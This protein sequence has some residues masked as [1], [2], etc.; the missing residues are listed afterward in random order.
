MYLTH[1]SRAGSVEGFGDRHGRRGARGT[2][3]HREVR[4][5]GDSSESLV[6]QVRSLRRHARAAALAVFAVLA[7][8]LPA[9]AQSVTTLVSN[10][11]QST[12]SANTGS[13]DRAQAFTTG[14]A[15]AT[16]SSV[17][18]ISGDN[19]GDDMAVSLCTVDSSGYPTS[20]CTALTAPSSFASGTLVF[21]DPASTT[22]DATTTYTLLITSPG[23]QD[24]RLTDTG[25][26]AEETGAA[27]GWTIAN[28][29]HFKSSSNV[30]GPTGFG[31]SFLITIKG[32]LGTTNTAPTGVPTITGTAQVGK[33]LTAVTTGIMDADGL[34]SP[35]YTYQWIRVNGTEADIAGANSSTYAL[36]DADLGKTIKVKV[37]FTDDASHTETLTSA[38]TV[39]VAAD[40][41]PPEVVRVTVDNTGSSVTL[42]FDEHLDEIAAEGLH[43]SAISL[44]AGAQAVTIPFADFHLQRQALAL[45]YRYST[46]KQGQT[47]VVSY[48]DPTAGDDTDTLQDVAGNDVASFTTGQSG[49]PAVTNNST[50]NA[51]TGEPAITG[52]AQVGQELTADASPIMDTDGLASVSYSYQWL[53]V[54]AD[55]TSNEEA[56]SGEIAATYTLTAADVGKRIKVKVSFTDELSGLE[57]RTSAAYPSSGTVTAAST[58]APA[59]LSV[60][61]TSTPHKTTDTYG[62]REHIEFSMTFDAP[63]TVT[64]A[65]T[66]AFDLGGATA[67]SWYAG[68]GTTTLRFSHAVSGGSSGDRDTNGI[69][70]AEN[71]IA[72]NGGTIAGTDNAVAAVLTHVAQSNLA[73]HKVD[74]RTTAVTPATVTVAVTSTPTSLA[75][76]YGFGETIVITVTASEAVEVEGDPEFE[77]SMNN[78]GGAANDVP[79][80]YDRTRSSATTMAFAY[81]VQAGDMDSDGIWIGDHS[82]TFMLDA[83]DRIRTASQQID[84][85]R[86]HPEKGT[87]AGHKVNG[88]LGAPTVPPDPTPPTL[89]LA[90]A[91][92]LTIEWTHPGDGGSP[93]T[94][95][96]IEY[97]VEGTTDWTNW[98]RGETPTQVTRAVIRNLAAG[99]AYDVRV[100]S[101]NA[102]GN[103]Q[104]TQSATA[105]STLAGN[106]AT[107]AP[108]ITGTAAVGQPLAVDLTGIEDADGLTNVSY[109]YQ[110]VRVDADGTSNPADIADATDATYT[111]V[112]ADLGT[113]LKVRVTFDDD[114]GSTETLTSAA[115]ATVTPAAGTP[116]SP[117]NLSVTVGVGQVVLVWQHSQGVGGDRSSYEYR[118]SAGA[119][120]APDAMWQ[121]VQTSAGEPNQAYFQV[122]K[123]LTSGTT[124]TFQVRAEN[125]QGGSA[126]ATVTATPVSQ[127]SCTI[128]ALGDRRLLWQGQLTA[129]IHAI[130][131]DG[132]I[133]T[134]YGTGAEVPGTL[135][136]DA[137]TFRS[138]SYSVYPRT[139]DDFLNVVL[140]EQDIDVWYPRDEVVD[141]LRWHVC[142]TPYDFSSATVAVL[143]SEFEGYQWDVGSPWPPGIERTLR[144]SLPL[145]HPATGDPVIS[146]TVQVDAELTALTD[147]IM[148]DDVLDDVFTYQW[149]RVDADGTSNE[150]DITDETDATY[151][152]T[153]D[154]RGKQ[155]KVA[156]RFVDILGGEE[157]RTSAP[158]AT[159]AGVPNTAATGAPTITGTAQVGETLT[160]STTGIADANG[161]TSPTYTYQWIRVDADGTSNPADI[162]D[163]TDATYTLVDADLG[164]TLKVRVT[165]DDDLGHTETL[166]SAATATVGA[167]ATGPPTVNDVA[168]TSTPA[169]GN[170]YY[171]AGEVIEFTVT[172]S[173][174]VTVT[175][176]PKFAFRLGAA[177][178]QAAYA[179]GSGSAAL[180][181]A[182]TVQAG[183]VDRNGISWNALA[184]ALDG[185]TITQ[186]GATTAASLTHAEQAPLEGHRVDAAPPMQVSASVH[187]MSLVLVY[188]EALDPASMPATGAYTVTATVGATTTNPAVSEVSIYGIWVTLTLDAAPAAGATL[189]LAYA[190]P[191]SNP[192]QDEAGNDAP[193]FSGQSVRLGPLP[194][195]PPPVTDLAQVLGVGVVPGNAQ[196][197]VTWTAVS[198]ATGY[199]VQWMSSG[200]GYNI[201][202]RQATV[203]TGSTTRY[204]IPSLTNGTEYTVR[205]IATRT[206]ADDGP[207]SD[208][209]TGTPRVPPPPPPPPVTDLAQVMGVGVVPGNAQLVVTWTAVDNATGYTV[210]W[211]SSGQGY[212]TGDRQ[213]T[214]TTGSTTR[215]TIPSLT[216]GTEYTVRV[217]A[218]RT[219]ADDGPP[220]DE[221]TGT[222][223]VPPPPPPLPVTD[224]A[225]VMG[226]GVVPGN[227]QLVVTWTAVD[228]ATGYTVQWMSSGQG[229]NIGDRQATVTP[230]STTRY[231]IPSLTNGTEYTVRVIATRTGATDGPPSA[232][233]TGTPFT[234]P[235]A[236]QHLSGVPGDEQVM[237]T[238]DAPSSDGGSAILRYEY[239][240]DDSGTW[241]DAGLDLEETVPGLT[242][243]QQYAFEVRAVNSAG[244]G[245]PARTAATPLG[246]PSVPESLTA[247]GGD[248]EVVL[249]WTEPADDG[250][251]PVTGYGYR[252]AAGQA[253]PEDVTWRDAGTELTATVSGLENETRYTFE[254][255][256]RNR[257]GPGETSG[258]TALPLRLRAELFSS[259]V[260]A[261]EG[262][263]LVVGVRRSGRLAF[264][265]HAYIGVTDSALPGVT[266]TEEGRDDGLGRHR[267][268]FAAGAA[269]ATVTVT[270]VFDGERRQDRV[271]TATLDSA[272]LEVDG[273]RRPY[274]L[275]TPTLVVP[276]TEGDAGLSVADARVQGKSSVLAFTV[277]LDRTRDVAVRVDYATED[278]SARAGEDYTPVSGTLTIEAG[279]RE[280]TVEVPVLP[281]LHV[282]GERTLTLRLSNAVSAVIDDGVATGVIVRESELPK[283]WLAR[284]G[285]TA[286][287][288]A[289]QAIARRLEAG[290]RETQ[291]TVAGRRVDGLSVDGLLS[292]A[293]PS[294]GW[295]PASA[296]EDMATRLAAPALAASGAPFGGVDADPGTPGLRAGTWGGAPGALDREPFADAGQTLR[297]A[298]LPDFG[299]RLPGAEE[300]LMGTSF[301]VER[302][303]QQDVGGGTW[304]AWGDVAATRFE[305][306]AGG[307]ALNGDVV[308][309]TAGLDRQWRAVL[310]GLAL[311]RSSGEG[312]YGTGAGTIASTLTS[313]HP[314]VQVRL[315]ERAQ[316][317]GAAGWGRGGLEITPESGAALEADLRNSMAAAG[318]RAVLMGAGGLEIA[319]RSDFLWTETASDGTAALAEAV[320]TASRGRL[321]LEGA[322]QIQGL[323]G[324]VRPKVEGGVRY[325]R[326]DAE[327]GRGF[328]VGGGLDWA[329]GSL[330]LQVN[331]RMLVAHADESYEEWGYSGSLVYEPGADGLGLQMRVGSSAGAAASGIRNL[332]ALEN[333][334]GLVR[335]GAVPFAQRFDAEVGYGLGRGTLWY[336]YFVADDSGQTRYGLKLSSGRT[337]GVGLEFGRR[338]SVDLGPQDAM[339]IRGEL[340]F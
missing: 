17:E 88:S 285:R 292:G 230:G 96:F 234:T 266:A 15:G 339:L 271:L 299:F 222:P 159:L 176:T 293:L 193:A 52:T 112:D 118:S 328:E 12:T 101:T 171:L 136:P 236:P 102:I 309:G 282:T 214:V 189:T 334:S 129:G 165:F 201:G 59:L 90:T 28:A 3:D 332:W 181:F 66:F 92:T 114:D 115:T 263:A 329:R 202:D 290:Q 37:S 130:F 261:A 160:A 188:D 30:W 19:E 122:V 340:R 73:D 308:T 186:T 238:W 144:L 71:A 2:E 182:R 204:T 61:V 192:V 74:G 242:N 275:V 300:A 210:Q 45:T 225:Q 206:G 231:T 294:G 72:L 320:G 265:A 58:T 323:G 153:A 170:T 117:T 163:E 280:R 190:P 177:T 187:G 338:E 8:A 233:V 16:L 226:V 6:G 319:L 42:V 217:I 18:I 298:V 221:M 196:L 68:S 254:V 246:M 240:I 268:E 227:A 50:N 252:Y 80:T 134:G 9:A 278:G 138:T 116:G 168:V 55:G 256:A 235:G 53:R 38:A 303:A 156:V 51:A 203:T 33:T 63:V 269:E 337:I 248:G 77:F 199:T 140:R 318:A 35:T 84:I 46:I 106:P 259:A 223:R 158:T 49:V 81:T 316:V 208:E 335:G 286:S 327:T 166:T 36:V 143:F 321:M 297:R 109:S 10:A 91:T 302:G 105:F 185:G 304:A 120:I 311:S 150:E 124:H 48:T 229:Y 54:D 99:T 34:T 239:A 31:T 128:D 224:L 4:G 24:L 241:I 211:T 132:S 301:Y 41:T 243:G 162:T 180:V 174:P 317:W 121:Q 324:V 205:V 291:V 288:H 287:D 23:G 274:E 135:T 56:I 212:N 29:Y 167:A 110:W 258:T 21:T 306:D 20:S 155:V 220:S 85:D 175:A 69:S 277:S 44:T 333:A 172:F 103:S 198:N 94:R 161:L 127:P 216:N 98:Y 137:F 22:L 13:A 97:R 126:P 310:V 148:D 213:A 76:T 86:S 169:S 249:E 47:V 284:F 157:T 7:L 313:V 78:P 244:P 331:G 164:K 295:R 123:G 119:M 276:V 111:L 330:T 183:E 67:A 14:A 133:E 194:P 27:A 173:A 113:T 281:A 142:N 207:P 83:N 11:G 253:V 228:N 179:S 107:G 139:Y 1:G 267:L 218:T 191:A 104:W 60:T 184:L 250:G 75:D 131:T 251:S 39:T 315:G 289:A 326:G 32:T 93:L 279:G 232:E 264:P 100:H 141:A 209:M 237:L 57:T 197:V 307:L 215:Y 82:R 152:L 70:W 25:S 79:A 145:N 200:Q 272:E 247:T 322:G 43:L 40:T 87:L 108:T 262:E 245:A 260:L 195:P 5:I 312:G 146:G 89:V 305:G 314:Y 149:V 125:A 178:R 257:V 336:P 154:D 270:V 62:A 255:R 296:V 147:G 65:P 273:V 64:G 283:A 325:D 95:N 219:G 26:N 151:T